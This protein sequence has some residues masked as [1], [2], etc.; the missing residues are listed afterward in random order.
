M[1]ITDLFKLCLVFGL[2]LVSLIVTKN[3]ISFIK[4]MSIK[5]KEGEKL[6]NFQIFMAAAFYWFG[7]VMPI[8]GSLILICII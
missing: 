6:D 7:I 3:C 4:K 5:E 2:L 8:I 1:E